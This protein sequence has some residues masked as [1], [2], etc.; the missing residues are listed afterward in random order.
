MAESL[1]EWN[2]SLNSTRLSGAFSASIS[3][4][5]P[6]L[7]LQEEVAPHETRYSFYD[8]AMVVHAERKSGATEQLKAAEIFVNAD[9]KDH[10]LIFTN[11]TKTLFAEKV[12]PCQYMTE[13]KNAISDINDFAYNHETHNRSLLRLWT[14][15]RLDFVDG[16]LKYNAVCYETMTWFAVFMDPD[17][18]FEGLSDDAITVEWWVGDVQE[19]FIKHLYRCCIMSPS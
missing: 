15:A 18:I 6:L 11:K 8:D 2:S 12:V 13:V 5:M 1:L 9:A 4:P 19:P 16:R 10:C 14:S 7:Y 3:T 17:I